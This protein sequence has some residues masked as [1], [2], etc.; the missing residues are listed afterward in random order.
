MPQF[1]RKSHHAVLF[2][3]V[4]GLLVR[5]LAFFVPCCFY[6]QL[7][8]VG[9]ARNSNVRIAGMLIKTLD[10][11]PGPALLVVERPSVFV[12]TCMCV[13]VC[14]C[15]YIYTYIYVYMYCR[16]SNA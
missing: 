1:I 5:R 3:L 14:I 8:S 15:I 4:K 7:G 13:C 6:P 2:Q 10:K 11:E 9:L 16:S 12:R